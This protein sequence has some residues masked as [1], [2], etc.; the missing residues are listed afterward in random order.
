MATVPSQQTRIASLDEF[1]GYTVLG[2]F[3]VNFVGGFTVMAAPFTLVL[4]GVSC[5][6][7]LQ[8]FRHWNT[9]CGYADTIMPQFFFAVGFAY[10][11]TFL[12]RLE[13][14]GP[15]A[16]Y[17]KVIRRNLG[18]I[19]LGFVIYHLD[20]HY[21]T[22]AKLKE[23]GVWG[24]FTT[25]F[26]RDIFQTL[27]HIGVTSLW[28]MP[29]IAAGPGMRFLFCCASAILHWFLSYNFYY[30]WVTTR[31]GIDG[32]YLGFMTWT[33][34]TLAGT[35]AYDLVAGY[36]K[37][38]AAL[39]IF[40]L[41]VVFMAV[42]YAL[43]CVNLVWPPNSV[44]GGGFASYLVEPPFVAPTRPVNIWTMSQRA[45]SASYLTFGAGLSLSLYALFIFACDI[46][47]LRVGIF[48]TLGSNALAGYIIHSLV[49]DA[50]KPFAPKDSPLWYVLA[51]FAVFLAICYLFIRHMEKQGLY[52]R[53]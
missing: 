23:L 29:V 14:Q 1:R 50:V 2:M 15:W 21:N 41:G 24:F 16:A 38:G 31:P 52:L 30:D 42:G 36:S 19:L 11:M 37:S 26:Q 5:V 32:G 48:R 8:L 46:G 39:R 33:V 25:A 35:F 18:L 44:S 10:R 17:T 12:R 51:A 9:Y 27:V 49:A 4:F 40:A 7:P 3:W 28:I 20:G 13:R 34:P 47:P 6:L 53:L 43:A 45:G 22:W